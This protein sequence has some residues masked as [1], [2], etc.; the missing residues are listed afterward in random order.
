MRT[1]LIVVSAFLL[2]TFFAAAQMPSTPTLM[3][4]PA[5][6]QMGSGQL[7]V[8]QLFTVAVA[9]AKDAR[10]DSGISRFLDQL[11]RQTGMPLF[12]QRADTA[13]TTLVIRCENPGRKIQELSEDEA[14]TLEVTPTRTTLTAPNTL[15]ALHGLQTFLQLVEVTPAGFAVPALT[16]QDQPRFA[17][18]G[19]LID[20]CRHF[21]PL[22]VMRRNLDGMAAL[23][24][25]V[26]HWHLS[27]D[28]GFRVESRKF[29]K[30]H[31]MGSQ[32]QYYTQAEIREFVSYAR[33]RGVRV[34]P[35]FEMPGHSRSIVVGYP[36][37]ASQPG[38]YPPG[39]VAGDANALDV[40][41]EKTYK[42]LDK[43]MLGRNPPSGLAEK[44]S[45]AIVA[46]ARIAG[47]SRQAGLSRVALERLLSRLDVA[48]RAPLCRRPHVRR[49]CCADTRRSQTDPR[50]RGVHVGRVHHSRNH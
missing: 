36:D 24:M 32:G 29:P 15:G 12:K 50:R 10:L 5:K 34:V 11:S 49:R 17:W 47:G 27:D 39:R 45:C 25:N 33:D 42:F 3:P 20:V 40:T 6:L 7:V 1:Q 44:C 30:L 38:P 35:E 18:R 19:L 14:Y 21:M 46:R 9:G 28:E 41:Q 16:I 22:D 31:E 8:D 48:R 23:K 26:L 43:L 4:V 13:K 37:L 2:S